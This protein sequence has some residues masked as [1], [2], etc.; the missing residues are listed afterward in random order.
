MNQSNEPI[1]V[2]IL[3]TAQDG[4]Y[5]QT[6]CRKVC[7]KEAWNNLKLKR[8]VSSLAILSGQDCWLIDIT[9]DFRYQLKMIETELND[10]PRI[11]G[12]FISHAHMGH[13]MGLLELGLEAM[14][15]HDI[16]V[17]VMPEMKVFLEENAPFTQLIKLNNIKLQLI[18]EDSVVQLNEKISIVPFQV[19]HR[20]EFSETVG[21]TVQSVNKSLLYIPD[22]DSWDKWDV[23]IND[24]ILIND[25][26]LLDGTFFSDSELSG[27]NLQDIPH[28]FI[29]DSLQKFSLLEEVDRKKVYFTHLNHTNPAIQNSSPER[30]ELLQ[31]GCHIAD[32][33]MVF[34][35]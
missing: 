23:D 33:G 30:L 4:G 3:G 31:N 34:R 25:I 11:S 26:L 20:N 29:Q 10:K 2:L 32:D 1:T 14:N 8:Q 13:Y 7:C 35:M 22:I 24:I 21:F 18:K 19:P 17:F 5:P 9:P 16:P 27:R 28:P 6:G 12:I 15:A